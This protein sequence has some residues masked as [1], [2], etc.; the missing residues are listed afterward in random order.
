MRRLSFH[1]LA[2]LYVF[3]VGRQVLLKRCR[4]F[5]FPQDEILVLWLLHHND[6]ATSLHCLLW[7][8]TIAKEIVLYF[9]ISLLYKGLFNRVL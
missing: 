3:T 9:L 1:V 7:Q 2:R 6:D 4:G 5:I 8:S